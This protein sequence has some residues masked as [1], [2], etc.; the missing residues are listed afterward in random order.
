MDA[1]VPKEQREGTRSETTAAEPEPELPPCRFNL[2]GAARSAR[3]L[4]S[5]RS[6]RSARSALRGPLAENTRSRSRL[7]PRQKATTQLAEKAGDHRSQFSKWGWGEGH[8]N[9]CI[10]F[11]QATRGNEKEMG[12]E[13]EP[14]AT[15]ASE[16]FHIKQQFSEK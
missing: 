8:E 9:K 11:I 12:R 14:E 5:A 16:Y 6:A 10:I 4:G 2:R 13:L 1:E 7:T 3:S 15:S